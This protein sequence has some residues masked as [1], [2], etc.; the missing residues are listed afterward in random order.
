MFVINNL[1]NKHP[2]MKKYLENTDGK[3]SKFWSI[4]LKDQFLH[5]ENGKIGGKAKLTKKDLKTPEKAFL[6]FYKES[7]KKCRVAM[8]I[9]QLMPLY[10]N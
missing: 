8:S 1:S 7:S 9:Q 4:E 2:Q 5:I 6:A 3:A 10:W